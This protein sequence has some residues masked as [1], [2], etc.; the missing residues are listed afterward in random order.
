MV[1]FY[2]D[3]YEPGTKQEKSLNYCVIITI[4]CVVIIGFILFFMIYTFIW[5]QM[6]SSLS[7]H[8]LELATLGLIFAVLILVYAIRKRSID[9]QRIMA[10]S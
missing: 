2:F 1:D 3:D 5:E 7:N 4:L 9:R 8:A 6:V 10:A